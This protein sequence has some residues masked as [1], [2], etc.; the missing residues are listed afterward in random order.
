MWPSLHPSQ[1]MPDLRLGTFSTEKL[2]N[3]FSAEYNAGNLDEDYPAEE[4]EDDVDEESNEG[5]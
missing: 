3:F 1:A 5:N 4:T 2:W